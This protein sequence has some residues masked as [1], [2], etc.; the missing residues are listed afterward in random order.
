M[1]PE[2]YIK[3]GTEYEHQVAFFMRISF[4]LKKWPELK[5]LHSITNEEKT[6]SV[7]VGMRARAS[8]RKAGVSD[9]SFP[10]KRKGFSGLYIEM[11][12]LKGK[13]SKEQLEFGAFVTEQGFK[14]SVAYGWEEA[15]DTLESYLN[16]E[17]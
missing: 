5:W 9:I 16:L 11:K 8:G 15:W 4:E 10:C 13:P 1:T 3:K 12:N 6:N 7:I 2:Q 14:F 17:K